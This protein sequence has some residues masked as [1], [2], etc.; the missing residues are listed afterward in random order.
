MKGAEESRKS[1]T[2]AFTVFMTVT[3]NHKVFTTLAAGLDGLAAAGCSE[4]LAL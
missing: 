3:Y 2:G 1:K 4:L